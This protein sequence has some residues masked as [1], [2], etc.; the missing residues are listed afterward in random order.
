MNDQTPEQ[1]S[2]VTSA[3][4]ETVQPKRR[5]RSVLADVTQ[6][7]AIALVLAILIKTF[8][9]QAFYIPSPS[10]SDT[11]NVGDRIMVSLLAPGPL[12][13]SRGDIVVFKDPGG[14]L[15]APPAP[16]RNPV[17]QAVVNVLTWVG[18]LPQDSGE[19]LVKRVIGLPGDTVECCN[20][21]GELLVN[22]VAITEPYLADPDWYAA[23][24]RPEDTFSVIVPPNAVWVMGD[25][26]SNSL[27]SRYHRNNL[28]DGAV[29]LYDVVGVAFLRSWP[30]SEI[31]LL[32]NP[33]AV[34][35]NVPD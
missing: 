33:G 7:L 6:T 9:V 12:E 13:L 24:N 35:A 21:A 18:L 5:R 31:G 19:H 8:L 34:F 1:T 25:N 16:Q 32:R 20:A 23:S 30:L 27:D 10:M 4:R 17:A 15:N 2:G 11:I 26:R 29:P 3:K 22:G 14:W 28:S